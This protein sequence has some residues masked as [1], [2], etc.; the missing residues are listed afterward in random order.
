MPHFHVLSPLTYLSFHSKDY[1]FEEGKLTT[2]LWKEK[3]KQKQEWHSTQQEDRKDS[4]GSG[5]DYGQKQVYYR[6]V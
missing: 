1:I 3:K 6:P 2:L 4:M 5:Q